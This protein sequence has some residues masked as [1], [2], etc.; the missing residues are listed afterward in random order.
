MRLRPA[1]APRTVIQPLRLRRQETSLL[2]RLS[3]LSFA[4]LLVLLAAPT[5]L[6]VVYRVLPP[7]VTP[8]MIIRLF[9]G[10]GLRKNWVPLERISPDLPRAVIAA[11]DNRFCTHSGFDWQAVRAVIDEARAGEKMR[12]AST[13]TMQTAK[14]VFLWPGR[15]VVRKAFEAWLTP[16]IELIWNKQRI[17]EVYLNVVEFGPGVYGAEAAA[18]RHFGKPAAQLSAKESAL[19]AAALPSP[20]T[21]SPREP[22]EFLQEQAR[23]RSTRV[24]QLGNLLD[25]AKVG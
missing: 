9:E 25:C 1:S 7:P 4:T 14:N 24:Q 11:E 16:Q 20:R 5:T 2:R 21:R 6:I 15:S 18:R 10:E 8:L 22:S 13:I 17:L 3:W 19:L 12:G 23:T